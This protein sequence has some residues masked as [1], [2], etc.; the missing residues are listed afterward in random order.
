MAHEI[1]HV[2]DP[3]LRAVTKDIPI[4]EIGSARIQKLIADM[5]ALLAKEEYGVALA[6]P[7][8]GESLRLFIVAGKALAKRKK[9]AKQRAQEDTEEEKDAEELPVEDQVY[10]NPVLLKLSR[11]KKEKHEGC[12]SVRGKWGMV[13]RAE[14]ATVHA[15]D[16]RG[17]RF[18]RGASGLLAHIFQHELDHLE[19]ILYTDK[20]KELYDESKSTEYVRQE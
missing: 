13:P 20:A 3:V 15:Y 8:V 16:E 19:G 6:A 11:T 17:E 10:I 12:L 5:K 2:G 7:Q 1:V 14:K 4:D 9:A 18:T